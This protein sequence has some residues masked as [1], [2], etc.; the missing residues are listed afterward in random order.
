M[1][2]LAAA[3]GAAVLL[4]L[5]TNTWAPYHLDSAGYVMR[6]V[7]F[8]RGNFEPSWRV[9]FALVLVPFVPL[10]FLTGNYDVLHAVFVLLSF[11]GVFVMYRHLRRVSELGA[12]FALLLFLSSPAVIY[13]LNIGKDDVLLVSLTF[14]SVLLYR[15]IPFLS[16]LAAALAF[17]AKE[18]SVFLLPLLLPLILSDIL[19]RKR[20][21]RRVLLFAAGV[22]ILLPYV[23]NQLVWIVTPKSSTIGRIEPLYFPFILPVL[24]YGFGLAG[25]VLFVFALLSLRSPDSRRETVVYLL[26]FLASVVILGSNTTTSYRTAVIPLSLLLLPAAV[27][28]HSLRRYSAAL[29]ALAVLVAVHSFADALPTIYFRGATNLPAH[30]SRSLSS[31]D[32]EYVLTMDFCG[33]YR[34][35]AG[36]NCITHPVFPQPSDYNAV[37]SEIARHVPDGILLS[38]DFFAYADNNFRAWFL[39]SVELEPLGS[40]W[41]EDYHAVRPYP[42]L[43]D[44]GCVFRRTG[45]ERIV[46]VT[47]DAGE[48]L[49]LEGGYRVFRDMYVFQGRLLHGVRRVPVYRV[50]GVVK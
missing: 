23:L 20:D 38:P 10:Y 29:V 49:C 7:E 46:S 28:A 16:G 18:P 47:V 22:V 42:R 24:L 31:Y 21:H 19:S 3:L 9:G 45:R 27:G 40:E 48:L 30:F 32:A 12:L 50:A 14:L 4:L 8:W 1:L 11:A 36:L 37:L 26:L 35:Y 25:A 39:S 44:T 43:D 13:T 17:T 6:A 41:Y 5:Y 34:Y 15:K 2:V 33:L